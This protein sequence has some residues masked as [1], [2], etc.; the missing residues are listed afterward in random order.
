MKCFEVTINGKQVCT[1]GIGDDGVLTSIV[2]FVMRRNASDK[3]GESQNDNSENLD[4]RV[5]GLT[6]RESGATEH[7]EWLHQGLA[8]GDEIV[9]RI[10]EASVCDEPKSKEVTYI[11]CSFCD[12]KQFDV[13]KLIAGPGVYICDECIGSCT[14]ALAAGESTGGITTIIDK[15]AEE[16]CSFCGKKPIEVVRIVGVPTALI[17]NECIKICHEILAADIDGN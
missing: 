16:S 9:I 2:S 12:K 17:C 10:I 6:N 15:T 3:P 8:V 7:V 11:Q 4:L 5:G 1:A 13:A 14:G